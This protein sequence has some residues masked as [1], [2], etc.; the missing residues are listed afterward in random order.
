MFDEQIFSLSLDNQNSEDNNSFMNNE[1]QQLF[2]ENIKGEEEN[3]NQIQNISI[4]E[5]NDKTK[6]ELKSNQI[7]NPNFDF[8]SNFKKGSI[9]IINIPNKNDK[10][11]SRLDKPIYKKKKFGR[12]KKNSNEERNH[13]KYCE[14]NIIRKIKTITLSYIIQFIN[15]TIYR[16]YNG[17]IGKGRFM[18]ELKKINQTQ[19][20]DTN[21]N[22]IFLYKNLR[23]IFSEDI[24]TKYTNFS[25]EHN[26]KLI[27]KLLIEK[28]DK[29]RILFEKLF[30]LN[31]LD[32]LMHIRGSKYYPEL[33]GIKI[34]D[35]IRLKFEEDKE[36]FDL[37]KY[38]CFNF[39]KI[40]MNKKT[41]SKRK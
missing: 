18:K 40:V 35:D 16:V 17:K 38:F 8:N 13:T 10:S 23:D 1:F 15:S 3:Q 9:N 32:C 22:K 37:L 6:T 12:K 26:K 33:D 14:D 11:E 20:T 21:G 41:R 31:F 39:E 24:S 25:N 27:E 34:L 28:D 2:I 30:S 7:K 29:K 36:Y 19:I 5:I 4:E